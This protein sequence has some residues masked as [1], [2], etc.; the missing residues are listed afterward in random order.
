MQKGVEMEFIHIPQCCSC[1]HNINL[2]K[3][4]K[5]DIKSYK[6]IDNIEDCEFYEKE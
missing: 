2:S 5:F 1:K 3:C 4:N 6:Y